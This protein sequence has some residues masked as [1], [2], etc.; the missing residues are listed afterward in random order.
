MHWRE[1]ERKSIVAR[2]NTCVNEREENG[3]V[4]GSRGGKGT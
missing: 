1:E 2:Q 4:T 3:E